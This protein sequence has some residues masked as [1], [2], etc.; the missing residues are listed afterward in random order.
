LALE[1][2][3]NIQRRTEVLGLLRKMVEK[4]SDT[5]S[6]WRNALLS[7]ARLSFVF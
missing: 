5:R 4:L 1:L 3:S 7:L 6:T 2:S